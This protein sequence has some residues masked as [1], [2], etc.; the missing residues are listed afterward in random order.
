MAYLAPSLVQLRAEINAAH[1]NRDKSSDG[2]I[3]DAAHASRKSDHNP[4]PRP[5]GVVRAL[6]VDKDGMDKAE[7]RRVVLADSR[8]EYFIQDGLIYQRSNGFRPQRYTGPNPHTSH[9][10]TSIRHGILYEDDRRPWGYRSGPVSP[11]SGGKSL[12]QLADEVIAGQWGNG[13]D[14][15]N[16]L[17]AAGYD[18]AAVQAEVN[19]RLLGPP[20]APKSVAQVVAEVIAGQWGNGDDRRRRLEAA[21]YN[22][23]E[24]QTEVNRRL[25]GGAPAAHKPSLDEIVNQVISGLWGNGVVRRQRL[26][27]AG[28]NYAEVQREVNRRLR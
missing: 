22:Y 16:R 3:G 4:D 14:R 12:A 17:R 8:T 2:W 27:G 7:L 21:G 10:H 19:R 1:P 24:V 15:K 20:A 25:G 18:P 11:P 26:E 9:A 13:D 6:D 23:H 5:N 28:Y